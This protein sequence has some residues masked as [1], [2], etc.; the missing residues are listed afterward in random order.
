MSKF[1]PVTVSQCINRTFSCDVDFSK[2]KFCDEMIDFLKTIFSEYDV[3]TMIRDI[4]NNGKDS[5]FFFY[6][7]DNNG[8]KWI[9]LVEEPFDKEW[10]LQN[11]FGSG[12]DKL[13]KYPSICLRSEKEFPGTYWAFIKE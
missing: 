9:A 5:E 6:G 2:A 12:I 4:N 13:K 1:I 11:W 3:D 7:K 10:L 8:A